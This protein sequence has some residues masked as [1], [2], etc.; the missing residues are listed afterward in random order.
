[1]NMYRI[2]IIATVLSAL[3]SCM[4]A[5]SKGESLLLK[6][7][8][9]KEKSAILS[10]KG[11]RMYKNMT[12]KDDASLAP[13]IRGVFEESLK[14]DPAN[15]DAGDYL[16]KISKYVNEYTSN[17]ISLA[18]KNMEKKQG[19]TDDDDYSLCVLL[20]K[21]YKADPSNKDV[22]AFKNNT[23]DIRE[24]LA[25]KMLLD[26]D[27]QLILAKKDKTN[28]EKTSVSAIE[29][30]DKAISLGSSLDGTLSS[31]RTEAVNILS[32]IIEK[33]I[34]GTKKLI[35]QNNF[36]D[37]ETN[38]KTLI[39]NNEYSNHKYD[40]ALVNLQYELYFTWSNNLFSLN[41]IDSASEKIDAALKFKQTPEAQSLQAKIQEKKNKANV[42]GSFNS[43]LSEIDDLIAQKDF[44]SAVK[45]INS[46]EGKV[47][48]K[49]RKSQLTDR[50]NIMKSQIDTIYTEAV[51]DFVNENYTNAIKGFQNILALEPNYKDA[52][53][54]LEKAKSKTK[55]LESY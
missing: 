37:A 53:N 6:N 30:F 43:W 44:V 31:K 55:I 16:T 54:Y 25:K 29:K 24:N 15:K 50:K 7:L 27:S 8:N 2:I 46:I 18:K 52:K 49:D 45:K 51:T 26:G 3:V 1:M 10:D 22:I 21:T 23:K 35:A 14:Y 32:V 11:I 39:K 13:D 20:Q 41:K 5:P 17:N 28:Q 19:R 33:N 48:E 34:D 47:K 42:A 38:I 40:D 12:D 9:D 4:N 36:K